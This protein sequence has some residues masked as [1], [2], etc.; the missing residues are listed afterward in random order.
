MARPHRPVQGNVY[1]K[2]RSARTAAPPAPPTDAMTSSDA[3]RLGERITATQGRYHVMA[4][5]L[6]TGRAC[7]LVVVDSQTGTEQTLTGESDWARLQ[8][9]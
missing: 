6:I 3:R 5:R 7:S 1:D 8:A 4:I 9:E 2:R